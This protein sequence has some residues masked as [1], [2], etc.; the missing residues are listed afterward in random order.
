[1]SGTQLKKKVNLTG[2]LCQNKIERKTTS[3]YVKTFERFL[4]TL[5]NVGV[6]PKRATVF[7]RLFPK[8]YKWLKNDQI[9]MFNNLISLKIKIVVQLSFFL[10]LL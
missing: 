6:G 4:L 10:S 9:I 2:I 8:S 5:H 7:V 1:M 3:S